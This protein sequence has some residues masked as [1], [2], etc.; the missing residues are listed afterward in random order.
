M[1]L[2]APLLLELTLLGGAAPQ[3][4][5]LLGRL[6]HVGVEEHLATEE[7]AL[8]LDEREAQA[9]HARSRLWHGDAFRGGTWTWD[10]WPRR[11]VDFVSSREQWCKLEM[12]WC[13][14]EMYRSVP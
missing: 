7:A 1:L 10:C 9:R 11:L 8:D 2:R 4:R 12:A 3:V 13:K 14:L 6:A 5:G